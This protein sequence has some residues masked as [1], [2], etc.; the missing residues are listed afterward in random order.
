MSKNAG[1]MLFCV[2]ESAMVPTPARGAIATTGRQQSGAI[3]N[4]KLDAMKRVSVIVLGMFALGLAMP[5]TTMAAKGEKKGGKHQDVF[6]QYDINS[7]GTLD[8]EEK[9]AIVKDFEKKPDGRLKQFDTDNDGKLSD[10][11]LDAIK[12]AG[13]GGKGGKGKKKNQ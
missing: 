13:K 12:P 7:D 1:L 8:K 2:Y 4:R 5:A 6:S 9:D 10:S 11:E 3:E